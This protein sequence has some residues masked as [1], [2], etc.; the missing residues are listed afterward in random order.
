[1]PLNFNV[2][3]SQTQSFE[4]KVSEQASTQEI[5][6]AV[7][8]AIQNVTKAPPSDDLVEFFTAKITA[9]LNKVVGTIDS[10]PLELVAPDLNQ[11]LK[12]SVPQTTSEQLKAIPPV[13]L[14]ALD[15][16]DAP[17]QSGSRTTDVSNGISY[18]MVPLKDR[19]GNQWGQGIPELGLLNPDGK[20]R[21]ESEIRS[22][23]NI[24]YTK[25][26]IKSSRSGYT[27][28]LGNLGIGEKMA[29][30]TGWNSA[31]APVPFDA[32]ATM[33]RGKDDKFDM[34][35]KEELPAFK[36]I[37]KFLGDADRV[38]KHVVAFH[39][40]V[41]E[42]YEKA[43]TDGKPITLERAQHDILA[44]WETTHGGFQPGNQVM[45]YQNITTGFGKL[46][47]TEAPL[48]DLAFNNT[49]A[50]HQVFS[51]R[52]QWAMI[53]REMSEDP[54][55]FRDEAL[56]KDK[57]LRSTLPGVE[58]LTTKRLY[59]LNTQLNWQASS[60]RPNEKVGTGSRLWNMQEVLF[61]APSKDYGA[62]ARRPEHLMKACAAAG[63]M[64][65]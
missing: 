23:G 28:K 21:V 10:E 20:P 51:H 15:V 29:F 44:R 46:A 19:A 42:H 63:C 65:F 7:A 16:G 59:W 50:E 49:D 55:Q 47:R 53:A 6:Q 26:S 60:D 32:L 45:A 64:I 5:K 30:K 43:K 25:S 2:K 56:G 1:M 58:V 8:K 57:P 62:N 52:F 4:L 14:R 33:K 13:E 61:D 39:D 34:F 17:P 41:R 38:W 37:H 11:I 31:D 36:G 40:E 54:D 27:F 24:E 35:R 48:N 22:L 9:K 3:L 12:T 18:P